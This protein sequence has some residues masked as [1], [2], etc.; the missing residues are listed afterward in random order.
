MKRVLYS[1]PF[2][3]AE[4][5]GAHGMQPSRILARPWSG[6]GS[7]GPRAGVCPHAWAFMQTVRCEPAAGAA[8]FTT[9]CDQMR[10]ASEWLARE[11]ALPI[12]LM[13]VPSTWQTPAAERLYISELER[14]GRFLVGLGGRAPSRETLAHVMRE[15]QDCRQA[16]RDARGSISP[17]RYAK[18]LASFHRDGTV[19][20]GSGMARR[21]SRGIPV[22]L[23]GGPLMSHHF[24][25][26]DLIE[27]AGGYVALDGTRTGERTLPAAFD[28]R[29]LADEPFLSLV[30]AYLGSIP[31]AFQRP[32]SPLYRWLERGIS[33]RGIRGLILCHYT[34]C[35]IWHAELARMKE[36]GKAAVLG[37]VLGA[38]EEVEGHTASRIESFLEMLR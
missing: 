10:R 36:W 1:C 26:F 16:L 32:N 3:P 33:E 5:I 7:G 14:L 9:T 34:W 35:D 11:T 18:A 15:Y 13:N 38:D 31:D 28:R 20:V 4:W 30:E 17:K 27:E 37:L 12:F 25:M 24:G 6:S 8:V 2:V 29:Q 22:A 23:V 21:A 19:E